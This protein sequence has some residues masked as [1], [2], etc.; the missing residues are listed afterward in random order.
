MARRPNYGW[1][2][3]QRELKKKKKKEAKALRK[4]QQRDSE[5]QYDEFGRLIQPPP[6]ADEP[7]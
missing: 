6:P 5:P 4:Q 7:T 2:K 1:E 3:R